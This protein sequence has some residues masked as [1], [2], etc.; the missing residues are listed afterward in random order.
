MVVH[1]PVH[2]VFPDKVVDEEGLQ[3]R[4]VEVESLVLLDRHDS[5]AKAAGGD[6]FR[7]LT[8]IHQHDAKA[9]RMVREQVLRHLVV[10]E[11][12]GVTATFALR[13]SPCVRYR[14]VP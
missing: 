7:W 14:G 10:A 9:A 13:D 4:V 1:D 6:P 11:K 3:Q 5:V 2:L 12:Q 8:A